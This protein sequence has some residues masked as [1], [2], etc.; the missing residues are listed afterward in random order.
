MER[1]TTLSQH[2]RLFIVITALLQGGLMYL[3]QKGQELGWW[4]FSELT[5]LIYWYTLVISVP[6]AMLLTVRDLHDKLFWQ[7]AA[8]ITALF[9]G[10]CAWAG[11]NATGAPGLHSAAVLAPFGVSVA[12]GLFIAL[13]WLQCRLSHRRWCAPY[14]ELVEHAW[15]N[16]LT[17]A[18]AGLFTGISWL[19]LQLWAALFRLIEIEF[20]RELFRETA[21]I[22]LA[23]GTMVGLGI[24]IGRSQSRPIQMARQL[25]FALCRGLLPLLSFVAVIFILSLPFTGLE[26]LWKTRSAAASLMC[27]VV[28][29]LVF[30]NAVW[31]DGE[32]A[33]PYPK[34]LRGLVNI[35]MLSLPIY[36]LLALYAMWLRIDQY[37]WTLERFWAVLLALIVTAHA[38][39]YA[40]AAGTA[41]SAGSDGWLRPLRKINIRLSW[42]VMALAVLAN[43]PLLDPFRISTA[44]QLARLDDG[45]TKAEDLDLKYLR[46]ENGR[47]GYRAVE[48]LREH[49]AFKEDEELAAELQRV[50]ER[51]ARWGQ[52]QSEEERAR[53]RLTTVGELQ[54]HIA[55]AADNPA[56][57]R[58][59]WQA[60]LDNET[61]GGDCLLRDREC[62]LLT[63][64]LDGDSAAEQLLC[65]ISERG[66]VQCQLAALK[67]GEWAPQGRVWLGQGESQTQRDLRRALYRGELQIRRQRWPQLLIGGSRPAEVNEAAKDTPLRSH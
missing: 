41:W 66:S 34:W 4:P 50:I 43:T 55:L 62:V 29:M 51:T 60:L 36:G 37:G 47:R 57:P 58:A 27:L 3:A 22:Y 31:Q 44:S 19:V 28:L 13:P 56:P 26:P 35:G 17:L 38:F 14:P 7:H 45:R 10:L 24:L 63:R 67:A 46:F 54:Q 25:V 48:S 30:I 18:L 61:L 49:P 23:T 42:V 33:T 16:A 12:V 20:F 64:D 2:T 5:G 9:V 32:N 21:F 53:L 59:Y 40:W 52:P 15:Q 8:M 6:T 1:D 11:W 65:L 39:G